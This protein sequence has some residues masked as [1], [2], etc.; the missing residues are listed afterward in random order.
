MMVPQSEMQDHIQTDHAAP[1]AVPTRGRR[2]F[3][4]T[5]DRFDLKQDKSSWSEMAAELVKLGWQ[6]SIV[7]SCSRNARL[8]H[9]Q[10]DNLVLV[11]S[12]DA[13]LLFRVT[14]MLS[15]IWLLFRTIRSSDVVVINDD[16]LCW[17]PVMRA[18]GVKHI[19]LDIRTVPLSP[20]SLKESL[21]NILFWK[22]PISVLAKRANS[23]S[24]ITSRLQSAFETTSGHH[25]TRSCVWASGV[26]PDLFRK[27]RECPPKQRETTTFFYHGNIRKTRG[28]DSLIEAIALPST[29][30]NFR[31]ELVGDGPDLAELRSMVTTLG[32]EQQVFFTGRVSQAQIPA[33]IAAADIC[34]CL[35]PDRPEWAVS[36]PLKILE[37]MACEKPVLLSRIPAHLDIAGD[38]TAVVWSDGES[39]ADISRALVSAAETLGEL[40]SRSRG[41]RDAVMKRF[42]W[43]IHA[44]TLH[45]HLLA[46][47]NDMAEVTHT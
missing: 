17:L 30:R 13:P 8:G 12:I 44:R 32:L 10:E 1:H 2:L 38:L 45:D 22:L 24:F 46:T 35:L 28:L 39:P 4:I 16:M 18:I 11:P 29:P 6:V 9:Y 7:A 19:H 25:F 31:I 15:S 27:P 14:T 43:S 3:W 36:S 42:L 20:I 5:P 33:M 26:N 41:N 37:Y 34:I 23:Y 21:S 40:Q 47:V